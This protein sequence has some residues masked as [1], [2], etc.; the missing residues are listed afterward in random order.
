[1]NTAPDSAVAAADPT[2]AHVAAEWEHDAPLIN[3]RFDPTGR[4]VFATSEDRSILRFDVESGQK[5]V[6]ETQETWVR[7]LVFDP[8]GE[9]LVSGGYD[10]RLVWWSAAAETPG[11]LRSV[12][13]HD[14]WIRAAAVHPSGAQIATAGN[15]RI[16]RLWNMADGALVGELAGHEK[17]VYSLL[18]HPEG[19]FLLSGDLAGVIRQWDVASRQEVRALDASALHTYNGGQG[20]D[21]GGVRSM[22]LSHDGGQLACSG[23]T[24]ATNPLGA[25]NEPMLLVFDWQTGELKTTHETKDKLKGIAWRVVY[26]PSGFLIAISG[27]S[28][29]GFVIFWRAGEAQEFFVHKL[30]NTAREMDLHPDGLRIVTAHHDGRLRISR[31]DGKPNE[32][33][34][35]S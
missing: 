19:Q 22:A 33:E 20:V 25:V 23:L 18:W 31:L 1:M 28:G 7:P 24:A 6:L 21:Y 14:G 12:D 3:C 5:F 9:T 13:A 11:P 16:V 32:E 10:G 15:A 27:G 35:T 17:H 29:G 26:H 34:A 4:F 2:Q 30:P 8:T